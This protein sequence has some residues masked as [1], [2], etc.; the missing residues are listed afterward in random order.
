MVVGVRAIRSWRYGDSRKVFA[1]ICYSSLETQLQALQ[2]PQKTP[3]SAVYTD[4]E[5]PALG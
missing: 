5:R 1:P 2:A 4:V 3:E